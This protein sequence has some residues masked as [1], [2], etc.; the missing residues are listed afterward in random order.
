MKNMRNQTMCLTIAGLACVAALNMVGCGKSEPPAVV[1]ASQAQIDNAVQMR[2]MFVKANG[3]YDSLSAEDKAAYNKLAG[4]EA[5]GQAQWKTMSTHPVAA[6][7]GGNGDPR[8][9][10]AGSAGQ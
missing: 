3:N 8:G 4:S 1:Q 6:P 5:A 9:G 10:A 2:Q 7:S